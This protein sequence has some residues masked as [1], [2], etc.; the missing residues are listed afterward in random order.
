MLH[1]VIMAGGSGTRFWPRSTKEKPKQFLKIFGDRTMLQETVDRIEPVIPPERV[2]VITN[3]R[4]MQL[5]KEQLPDVPE[6]NIIG[7]PVARNTAPCVASAAT[8]LQEKDP[9]ATM[10][11][12]PA[13]HSIGNPEKF[14]TI[15]ETAA[16][17]AD[18]DD[19]LITIGIRPDRPETGYGYI[20]FSKDS[21]E[22]VKGHEVKKVVQFREKPDLKTARQFIFSGNFLWNSGMF[23]WKAA[24]IANQFKKHLPEVYEQ[25]EELE[26][27]VGTNEQGEAINNFYRNC[28][29]ISI[30]YGIMEKAETV[31]VVPG[32][33]G[34][35]DVG[36]WRAVY[37]L[38]EKDEKGNVIQS[39]TAILESSE[40]NLV[41]SENKKLI[42]LVGVENLAVVETEDAIL[43][44][45]LDESQGVK[46]IVEALKSNKDLEKYL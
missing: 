5:V 9:E 22:T 36:S 19:A 37:D 14:I 11:V 39:D 18:E 13:D 27:A 3:E 20:E 10:V 46:Q 1:A 44:C 35:N 43:V 42:T 7:E 24:V 23:V 30:D 12:L 16:H 26:P 28:P 17:K 41:H 32:E 6:S 21:D 31:Y 45:N 33:F 29:S 2:W 15:L 34:W 25:M 8:L 38:R 40:N 4:Y